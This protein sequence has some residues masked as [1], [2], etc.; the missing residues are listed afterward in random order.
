MEQV[1]IFVNN[2][3]TKNN[4]N[5]ANMQS[6]LHNVDVLCLNFDFI[7]SDQSDLGYI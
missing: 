5:N 6:L 4:N 1:Q 3:T 2:T 7:L